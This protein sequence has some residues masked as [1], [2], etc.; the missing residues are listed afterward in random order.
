[1]LKIKH[2]AIV[3]A[4]LA[5]LSGSR[6][7]LGADDLAKPLEKGQ[8]VFSAGH[9]FHMFMPNMLAELAKSAGIADHKQVGRS[10]IGGSYTY[11]H[12]NVADDKNT[13]KQ[14]L[15]SGEVDVLTLA[16]IYL[17]DDGI[18]NFAKLAL[19]HN[20]QIRVTVQEFWLPYDVYDLNY[21][22]KKPEPVDRNAR[23]V[24]ELRS[25]HGAYFQSMDEHVNALNQKFAK[26]VVFV[27]PVGQAAVALRERI[28]AGTAPGLK[29]QNDLFTD[30][31]GHATPPLQWLCAYCHFAVLYRRTPVGLECPPA[32]AKLPEGEAL[33]T[34][35]QE[36]AWDAARAHAL[37][38]VKAE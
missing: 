1:M 13:A 6:A 12:W 23:T 5:L 35:L 25:T 4:A 20:P 15:K 30:A 8:R 18:E 10:S 24:E 2:S 7:V 29:Q 28:I 11:Q 14:M 32:M 17:P 9:S 38:G 22:R 37:S 16:P 3:L 34:L 21:K 36:L 33:N 26:P 19:E 31:I 27:V